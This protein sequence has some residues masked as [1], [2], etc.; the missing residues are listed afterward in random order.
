MNYTEPHVI[1]LPSRK[2][3][4]KSTDFNKIFSFS[5]N[6]ITYNISTTKHFFRN[7]TLIDFTNII[8]IIP[9]KNSITRNNIPSMS[10]KT[11]HK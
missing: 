2:R 5:K 8:P 1:I 6:L 7:Y 3:C 9:L 4:I 11:F 10:L